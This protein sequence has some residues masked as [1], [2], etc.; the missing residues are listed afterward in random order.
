M[1]GGGRREAR[2]L[3]RVAPN[4][5]ADEDAHF[6]AF[7]P[8]EARLAEGEPDAVGEPS[9]RLLRLVGLTAAAGA[10]AGD[11]SKYAPKPGELSNDAD[12]E[13]EGDGAMV[14]RRAVGAGESRS[15]PDEANEESLGDGAAMS[16]NRQ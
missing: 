8:N 9:T 13:N 3:T 2:V 1:S 7:F 5:M 15:M 14:G 11:C 4:S 16:Y 10:G 6:S 12:P